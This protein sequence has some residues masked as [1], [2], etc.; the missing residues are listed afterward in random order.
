MVLT[1]LSQGDTLTAICHEEREKNSDFPSDTTVRLWYIADEPA[2]FAPRYARAREA[3]AEAWSDAIV[4]IADDGSRDTKVITRKDGTEDEVADYEWMN[5]SRL[6]VD[7][8]KWLMAKLHPTR[9]GDSLELR[10][11]AAAPLVIQFEK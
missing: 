10:G 2:G 11:N 3:Q 5:R 4:A 7:T 8:R 9:Y 1:R 6:R